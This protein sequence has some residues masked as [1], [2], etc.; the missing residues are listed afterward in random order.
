MSG[1][2]WSILSTFPEAM[3]PELLGFLSRGGSI[4]SLPHLEKV[5]YEQRGSHLLRV[6][7]LISGLDFVLICTQG[8]HYFNST[9]LAPGTRSS[10]IV[11]LP[12]Y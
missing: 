4:V 8:T 12:C 3:A 1:M 9:Q 7:P 6:N 10:G 2:E 5:H 11:F